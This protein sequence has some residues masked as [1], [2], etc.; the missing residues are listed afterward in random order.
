[1]VPQ[2]SLLVVLVGLVDLIPVPPEPRERKR[3]RRK[4]YPERLFLKALVIMI[5][6]QVHTPSGLLA[7]LGQATPEMQALRQELSL[8][9][10]RKL[11]RGQYQRRPC[12]QKR[13][14]SQ[15]SYTNEMPHC[16]V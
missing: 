5:V 11:D 9:S 4:T 6:R 1:M 14:S 8:V 10:I 7:I 16:A 12:E 3:G 13:A 2:D 15:A